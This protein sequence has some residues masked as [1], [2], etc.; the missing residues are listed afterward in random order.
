MRCSFAQYGNTALQIA[1]NK[2]HHS[3]VG[4]LIAA[5]ANTNSQDDVSDAL[6]PSFPLPQSIVGP[7]TLGRQAHVH[8]QHAAEQQACAW[9]VWSS[10]G[11]S[12]CSARNMIVSCVELRLFCDTV[13][14]EPHELSASS[15]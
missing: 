3:I 15:D 11:T 14:C 2:G 10:G 6:S 9:C 13:A 4:M 12:I 7:L 1:A 8:K 5:E